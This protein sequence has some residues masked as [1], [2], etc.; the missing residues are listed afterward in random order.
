MSVSTTIAR[1]GLTKAFDHLYKDPE[2]NLP[3]LM[4]WADKFAKGQFQGQ[5]AAIRKAIEDPENAYYP[6]VRHIIRDVDPEVMKTAAVNFFINA[7]LVAGPIQEELR[8]K[9]NCNIPWAILLD[10][11]SACNLHCVGCWAADYGNKLNLTFEELDDIVSQGKEMGVYFYL[12]SGGEPLVRKKDIIRLCE[13]HNDCMFTA[14]TNGTLIDEEFADEML[15]VKNFAPAISLEGFGEATDS[16]RGVGVY[17]KVLQAMKILHDRKLIY[18]ISCCYTSANYEAITS[19]EYWD[20]IIENGAYFVWYFHYMPVGVDASQELLL[21]PEQREFVYHRIREYRS[22]K[23]LFAIDFQNDGEFVNGCVA[24][25]R[26]YL[27]INANGDAEPCAFIHYADS[28]I[29]EKSLLDIMRSPLFMAYHDGQP[30]NENMMQP[31]PMLENPEKLREMVE[32]SGAKS[33]DMQS[34]ES[35]DHLCS[36][37]DSYAACWKPKADELWEAR[38]AQKASGKT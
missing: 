19:E 28:N 33:T 3:Q 24:G 13:K 35:A 9:Y 15:R 11:T 14:F 37:C 25:G 29:R 10:P 31:C 38:K 8:A 4:D 34:P 26:R 7:N 1:L 32:K 23:P 2:N 5:R 20:M 18:G 30:F 6:Y 12:F 27:H 21:S 17:E 22:R 36:K 16:R